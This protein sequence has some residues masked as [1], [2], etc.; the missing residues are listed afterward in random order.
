MDSLVPKNTRQLEMRFSC[1]PSDFCVEVL[2]ATTATTATDEDDEDDDGLFRQH[3]KMRADTADTETSFSANN[4]VDEN[5]NYH[6][7]HHHHQQHRCD[8]GLNGIASYDED[9]CKIWRAGSSMSMNS[10][11]QFVDKSFEYQQ[12]MSISP[13]PTPIVP[14]S[15]F[16]GEILSQYSTYMNNNKNVNVNVNVNVNGKH[17]KQGNG[18][19]Q[20]N[21]KGKN[22][23]EGGSPKGNGLWVFF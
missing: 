22:T 10:S 16:S 15:Y 23:D 7:H 17:R 4:D 3:N 8:H 20:G 14:R 5:E 21:K 18:W 6:R 1:K 13:L 12:Q 11:D 9:E 2:A 19:N